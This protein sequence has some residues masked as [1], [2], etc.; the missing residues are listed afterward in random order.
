MMTTAPEAIENPFA[1]LWNYGGLTSLKC[2]AD[3]HDTEYIWPGETLGNVIIRCR[4]VGESEWSEQ[5]AFASGDIRSIALDSE[6]N[7][8]R[9]RF[10]Y[11]GASRGHRGI[12]A[13]SLAVEFSRSKQGLEWNLTIQNETGDPLEIGDIALPLPFNKQFIN[14]NE[15]NYT[16]VVGRHAF[17]SGHGS[18][19][20]WQRPNGEGPYLLMTPQAGTKIEY[21]EQHEMNA[22]GIR[23]PY[24]IYLHSACHGAG[25]SRG[26]WRQPH[27][28]HTLSARG[29]PGDAL[30]YGFKFQWTANY[31][32]TRDALVE[33]GLFDVQVTPGMTVP[34]DLQALVSL[35][36]R[37]ADHTL[38]P[39]FPEQTR[40]EF[41]GEKTP[42]AYL[43]RVT[44]KR[45]GENKLT[46]RFAGDRYMLLEF[47]VTQALETLIKKRAAF[48]VKK[49]QHRDPQQWYNGLISVWDMRTAELRG[50]DNTD[51]FDYWWGYVLACDD[52]ALPKAPYLAAKNL[53]YPDADEI[54]AIEYYIDHFVW[55]KLQRTDQEEPLPYAIYG[56]PNWFENR[57]NEWGFQP[58]GMK[59]VYRD[60][61]LHLKGKGQAHVWRN[62]DY[63]HI[64]MLYYHMYQI[65]RKY[66]ELVHSLDA[67]GYLL[68]A[69]GTMWAHFKVQNHQPGWGYWAYTLGMYN[70]LLIVDLIQAL[71]AEGCPEEAEWLKGEWEKKVK[72][73]LYDD[74]YPF[75]SEYHFDTT[76]FE[77]SHAVAKYALL[78]PLQP[79]ENLWYDENKK[80]WFSHPNIRQEDARAFMEKQ[81]QSNIALRGWLEPAYYLLG[82]DFR[83]GEGVR[84]QLS[85]M[86]Q[87]G[88]WAILDYAIHYA[89]DPFP[90]LRL[91][92][93]SYLSSWSLMNT[94]TPE[95]NYGF[96]Y[97][98][99]AN[100]GASGWAFTPEK[101]GPMWIRK[102]NPRGVWFY[103]G[104]IEL[105]YIGALRT[106]A[107]IVA[108]DP[109]FG[110]MAYGGSLEAQ[111][112]ELAVIPRDGLRCRF[113]L[114]EPGR[115][116]EIN[117]DWDGFAREQPIFIRRDGSR[118]RLQLESRAPGRHTTTLTIRGLLDGEYQVNGAALQVR[119]GALALPVE[120]E[121]DLPVSL[122]ICLV[123]PEA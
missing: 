43:Y 73:F 6:S 3:V 107:T 116:L 83:G 77:T 55:G 27:T 110:L 47:F 46:V 61:G 7:P 31:D 117:T 59:H 13:F 2:R 109:L 28:S 92:Y 48:L 95:T 115:R 19:I 21:Y 111:G 88:G 104:E 9:V 98:G 62:Y 118:V 63:P 36:T 39:E 102:N 12:R 108:D 120:M 23:I 80:K 53:Y 30:R 72:Y 32:A 93:A 100:D 17:V 5:E 85:Y 71:R 99:E 81:I 103:D 45:L 41:L 119:E 112:E 68:R 94:G 42:G 76:A 35:R 22:A 121:G 67:K 25:E 10:L 18:F 4:K 20:F 66:P 65:A 70:E 50:P 34:E 82:S 122:D 38:E 79:D 113:Y 37:Q 91:G 75:D 89:S 69:Y 26:T 114:V 78:N 11:E 101:Y 8:G 87:L 58:E 16:R 60:G 105:G 33:E 49:Q 54:A 84:Y 74:P 96:W 64:M 52:T 57:Y 40:V 51:G 56:V 15:S 1:I 14:N 86:S 24:W 29:T 123:K 44:F 90:Y 97:P 106:A